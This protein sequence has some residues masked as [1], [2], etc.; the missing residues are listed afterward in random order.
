[1]IVAPKDGNELERSRTYEDMIEKLEYDYNADMVDSIEL[2][3]NVPAFHKWL[4]FL[5]KLFFLCIF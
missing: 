1:M 5:I 3:K 2:E 4:N